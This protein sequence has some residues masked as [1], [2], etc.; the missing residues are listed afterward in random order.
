MKIVVNSCFGGFR[1]SERAV[2]M[3]MSRKMGSCFKYAQTKY[4]FQDGFNEYVRY[5]E[6]PPK[7]FLVSYYCVRDL[8][9]VVN[10]LPDEVIWDEYGIRRDDPDLVNTVEEL[11][12]R[13]NTG[14]SRLEVVEIPDGVEY[15][16]VGYDGLES[17]H[18]K[19]RVWS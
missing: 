13:A 10:R 7:P 1:L 15:E 8:G 11:G 6:R 16:I 14:V 2:E 4:D 9:H 12:E 18:V 3:I 5:E 19:H 17:I